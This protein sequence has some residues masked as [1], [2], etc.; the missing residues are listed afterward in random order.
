M[1]WPAKPPGQFLVKI[2]AQQFGF[3]RGPTSRWRYQPDAP[4]LAFLD[5]FFD[6]AASAASK[7]GVGHFP[8]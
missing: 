7:D 2:A 8:N 4:P 6:G 5:N 3:P 1:H